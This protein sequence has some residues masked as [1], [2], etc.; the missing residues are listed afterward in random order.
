MPTEL[1]YDLAVDAT[2]AGQPSAIAAGLEGIGRLAGTGATGIV[3]GDTPD[4]FPTGAAVAGLVGLG[5]VAALVVA[6]AVV[7]AGRR[8]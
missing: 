1:G 2:G 4:A 5:V 8:R 6:G 3:E 7:V